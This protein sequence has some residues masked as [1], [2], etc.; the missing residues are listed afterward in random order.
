MSKLI[1]SRAVTS[2]ELQPAYA[3]WLSGRA[4]LDD[5]GNYRIRGYHTESGRAEVASWNKL[6][7]RSFVELRRGRDGV[8]LVPVH[9]N[10]AFA[11]AA[12]LA[13]VR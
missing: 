1:T 4:Y 6:V 11:V 12:R 13:S 3:D 8:S 9:S 10:Q 7:K 5:A 2:K